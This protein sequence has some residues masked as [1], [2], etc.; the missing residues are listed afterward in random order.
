MGLWSLCT[1]FFLFPHLLSSIKDPVRGLQSFRENPLQHRFLYKLKCRC[2]LP[3]GV[4]T[5]CRGSCSSL[6]LKLDFQ[7]LSP[8][9]LRGSAMS[10]S[11]S[12]GAVCLQQGGQLLVS[13]YMLCMLWMNCTKSR[14]LQYLQSIKS[15]SV[16]IPN[17]LWERCFINLHYSVLNL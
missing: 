6:F 16:K 9:W 2:L 17:F 1:S 5:S 10:C 15:L 11:R 4:C 8:S 12:I 14:C 3:C 13:S 7:R